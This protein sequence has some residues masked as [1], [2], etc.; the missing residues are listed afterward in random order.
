[1][2]W[3]VPKDAPKPLIFLA[4]LLLLFL[5]IFQIINERKSA[6]EKRGK[7]FVGVLNPNSSQLEGENFTKKLEVGWAPQY[8]G[9]MLEHGE[10]MKKQLMG[11]ANENN[12]HFSF[13]YDNSLIISEDDGYLKVSLMLRDQT[14]KI[15]ARL[16]ENEWQVVSPPKIFDRNYTKDTLEIISDTGEVF[17]QIRVLPDVVKLNGVFYNAEGYG[18][19][20]Y[21]HP[22]VKGKWRMHILGPDT[23]RRQEI[24]PLFQYPSELHLGEYLKN[25]R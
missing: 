6:K 13:L 16:I 17:L 7:R 4:I 8:T 11:G 23:K 3:V 14:G 22:K 12:P 2:G 19:E 20:V 1:M 21:P 5:A 24:K 9:L 25:R 15:L 10:N 18:L